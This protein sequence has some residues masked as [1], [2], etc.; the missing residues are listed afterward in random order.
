MAWPASLFML[1]IGLTACGDRGGALAVDATDAQVFAE[2]GAESTASPDA[3]APTQPDLGSNADAAADA[4]VAAKPRIRFFVDERPADPTSR[5]REVTAAR[6]GDPIAVVV[7]GLAPGVPVLLAFESGAGST[8]ALFVADDA[9]VVD[10]ARDAPVGGTA[11]DAGYWTAAHPDAFLW[12]MAFPADGALDLTVHVRVV[13]DGAQV[14]GATLA[15]RFINDGI[16]VTPIADGTVQGVFAAPKG[17]GPFGGILC[18]GGSEGGTRTGV[19]EAQYFA[20]LGYAALGVGYFGADGLPATLEKVPLEILEAD[21]ARLTADPRVAPGGVV[22]VGGSRGGELALLLGATFPEVS[23]VVA[24]VPS[25]VVWGSLS[26]A[27]A[28]GWTLVDAPLPFIHSL[29]QMG[30]LTRS[31]EGAAGYTFTSVFQAALAAAAPEEIAAATIPIERVEGPVLL[32]AGADD[33]LWPSCDLADIAFR[34][35]VASGH[36]DRYGDVAHCEASAGH[37]SVGIPGWSAVGST[38]GAL[39]GLPLI[40]GGTVAGNGAALRTNDTATR[41]LL[42]RVLG[43]GRAPPADLGPR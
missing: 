20:S 22:V 1:L 15:R 28:S 13:A 6:F 26:G 31:S 8:D 42:E 7:D 39:E 41:A 33:G 43:P 21:L 36:A 10:L 11:F 16:D 23:G 12:S 3:N 38:S 9:G 5:P 30:A 24:R 17:P 29:G 32:L 25:G 37:A 35:L 34:R 4:D 19:F 14:L 18:F 40:L 27:D 2:V